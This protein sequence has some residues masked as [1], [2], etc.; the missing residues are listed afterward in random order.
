MKDCSDEVIRRI[1]RA[2][3]PARP[4]GAAHAHLTH[5]PQSLRGRCDAP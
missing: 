2:V 1:A 5:Y 3:S 4:R